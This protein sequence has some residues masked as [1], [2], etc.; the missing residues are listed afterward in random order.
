MARRVVR[1]GAQSEASARQRKGGGLLTGLFIGLIAGL[2]IAAS[3]AWYFNR[4]SAHHYKAPTAVTA[5]D[6]TPP[7]TPPTPPM[8]ATPPAAPAA[9]P[10]PPPAAA[11]SQPA[12]T[13]SPTAQS[14]TGKPAEPAQSTKTVPA[15]AAAPSKAPPRPPARVD[16]TFYDILPGEQPGRPA[17][18]PEKPQVVA[19]GSDHWW[20]QVAALSNVADA[21]KL[22]ARLTLLG[23]RV[24]TQKVESG[25]MILHRI[26]VGPYSREEDSFGDLDTLAANDYEPRLL[27]DPSKP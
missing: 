26:R 19:R 15:K 3:L 18:P 6:I 17:T 1:G 20:L 27:K 13:P 12:P 7:T 23:L 16:F 5:F 11:K 9:E 25:G 22:K 8:A 21:D 24:T 4:E 2:V 14:K 10:T